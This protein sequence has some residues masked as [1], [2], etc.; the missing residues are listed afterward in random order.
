MALTRINIE[1][2]HRSWLETQV[3]D[4]GTRGGARGRYK[5]IERLY[6]EDK[7][8]LEDKSRRGKPVIFAVMMIEYDNE[9]EFAKRAVAYFLKNREKGTNLH[10]W[11]SSSIG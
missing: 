6:V 11:Q 4:H 9:S 8:D 3:F 5:V 10:F 2:A 7:F 1:N